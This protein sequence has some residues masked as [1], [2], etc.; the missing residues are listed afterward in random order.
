MPRG[1]KRRC[2][3]VLEDEII[4]KPAGIPMSELEI[5]EM[6]LDELEAVRLSD[7]ENKSQIEAGEIMNVSRGT[8]QRLL[9]SGR[10]KNIRWTFTF[11]SNKVKKYI[12]K[13]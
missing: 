12:F 7:Y 4:F 10:K 11:K 13:L 5:I 2:C 3:R 1:K 8:I 6:E 9:T